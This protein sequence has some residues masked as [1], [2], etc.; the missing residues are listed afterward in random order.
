VNVCF[1]CVCSIKGEPIT[2][3][4]LK[5]SS[6]GKINVQENRRRSDPA[7]V[8]QE[9]N[10]L[11]DI[12]VER[13]AYMPQ[14]RPSREEA[15]ALTHPSGN[16]KL[17]YRT[18]KDLA[19]AEPIIAEYCSRMCEWGFKNFPATSGESRFLRVMQ[20][21]SLKLASVSDP[22]NIE[23]EHWKT[24]LELARQAMNLRLD[25]HAFS[26][27]LQVGEVQYDTTDLVH[28]AHAAA[29]SVMLGLYLST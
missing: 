2:N 24:V 26:L 27:S 11:I 21:L 17:P 13:P 23:L 22:E 16:F 3:M 8:A 18:T 15:D 25:V 14:R 12:N 5:V 1:Q 6:E 10:Q 9:Y 29:V 28:C 4:L 19:D 7:I 20:S